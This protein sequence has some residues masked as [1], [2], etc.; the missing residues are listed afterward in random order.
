MNRH[1]VNLPLLDQMTHLRALTLRG[2]TTYNTSGLD[3]SDWPTGLS[4]LTHLRMTGNVARRFAWYNMSALTS[5]SLHSYNDTPDSIFP[6]WSRLQKLDLSNTTYPS[7]TLLRQLTQLR[8]LTLG[9]FEAD[10]T[11]E[12]LLVGPTATV[13]SLSVFCTDSFTDAHLAIFTRLSRLTLSDCSRVT[14]LQTLLAMTQLTELYLS[15]MSHLAFA[16]KQDAAPNTKDA[17]DLL[18]AALPRLK[19]PCL[20]MA[21]DCPHAK[22][23]G[24][25]NLS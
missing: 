20:G 19:T 18:R 3:L 15:D 1:N 16:D 22:C 7:D 17:S 23:K 24:R 5:L 4:A 6:F 9:M 12:A 21:R 25:H 13:T 11:T 10:I 2:L 8:K 14:S